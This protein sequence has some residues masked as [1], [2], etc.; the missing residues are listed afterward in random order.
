MGMQSPQGASY[1]NVYLKNGTVQYNYLFA[2][3]YIT[4]VALNYD[5]SYGAACTVHS[6]K[7]EMV[8]KITIFN[9]RE[10]DPI[11]EYETRGNLLLGVYWS[12]NGNI[13]AVGGFLCG[14]G[15]R[16]LL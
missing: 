10:Q 2:R 16:R 4:A 6:E 12:E 8:S 3:D 15:R 9:F 5:A 13:Y 14:D 1:L 11:A 7:G